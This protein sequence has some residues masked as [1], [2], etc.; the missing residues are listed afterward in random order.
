MRVYFVLI[1]RMQYLDSLGL[2][3]Y[4][5]E[6]AGGVLPISGFDARREAL[7]GFSLKRDL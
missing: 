2:H 5:W 7:W 6:R 4:I 3:R 1:L